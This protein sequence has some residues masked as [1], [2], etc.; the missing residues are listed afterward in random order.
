MAKPNAWLQQPITIY[1][2]QLLQ[3]ILYILQ[4]SILYSLKLVL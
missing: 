1:I 3:Y 4:Y 2:E